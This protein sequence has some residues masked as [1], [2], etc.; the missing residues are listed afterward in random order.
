MALDSSGV[1]LQITNDGGAS[2]MWSKDGKELFFTH[3]GDTTLEVWSV[4]VTLT[5]SFKVGIP[6]KLFEKDIYTSAPT[7][8]LWRYDV[9]A[10]GQRFIVDRALPQSEDN[11]A[12]IHVVLNWSAEIEKK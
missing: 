2:P 5:P 9:T 8:G 12:E 1:R 7:Y 3:R 11:S 4:P 10:D 6:A